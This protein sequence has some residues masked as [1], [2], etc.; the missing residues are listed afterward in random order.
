MA[1]PD[2]PAKREMRCRQPNGTFPKSSRDEPSGK[3]SKSP[4]FA[5]YPG[6][7]SMVSSWPRP[8]VLAGRKELAERLQRILSKLTYRQREILK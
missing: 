6:R 1:V 4:G 3:A 8:D 5:L 2:E 7:A